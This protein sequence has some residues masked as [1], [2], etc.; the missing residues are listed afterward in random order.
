MR[1]NRIIRDQNSTMLSSQLLP[2]HCWSS[3]NECGTEDLG[4]DYWDGFMECNIGS[5]SGRKLEGYQ[6]LDILQK[7]KLEHD[8]H[9][10]ID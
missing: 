1:A 2:D 9:E 6:K 5:D 3:K 7:A 8:F 4:F 10:F